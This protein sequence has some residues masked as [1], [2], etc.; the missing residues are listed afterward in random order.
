MRTRQA[1]HRRIA[2]FVGVVALA[3]LVHAQNPAAPAAGRGRG[4]APNAAG[5]LA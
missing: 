5:G 4:G 1:L 2:A 3:S